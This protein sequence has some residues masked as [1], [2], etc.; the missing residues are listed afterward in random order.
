MD[1]EYIPRELTA[2]G[3]RYFKGKAGVGGYTIHADD[4]GWYYSFFCKPQ[5]P[6]ARSGDAD[7]FVY[8]PRLTSKRRV[9]RACM[10]RSLN[11][12]EGKSATAGIQ[13]KRAQHSVPGSGYCM[14][15]KKFVI[16]KDP[17]MVEAANGRTMIQGECPDCG[18]KVQ[19][20]GRLIDCPGCGK[21]AEARIDDYLCRACREQETDS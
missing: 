2:L 16:I 11:L 15:E 3:W 12:S 17:V 10:K 7:K 13:K 6:G 5:G 19:K 21:Y 9:K 1:I 20:Y 8:V 14:R 18:T 4:G